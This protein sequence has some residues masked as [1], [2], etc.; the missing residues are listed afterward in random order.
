MFSEGGAEEP[1]T[2]T[3]AENSEVLFAGSVAV[4]AMTEPG[5][6]KFVR[7]TVKLALQPLSVVT[8]ASPK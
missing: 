4:A 7:I 1:A 5:E 6:V 8:L 2:V 3:Q